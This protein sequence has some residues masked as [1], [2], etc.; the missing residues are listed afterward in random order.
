VAHR[1]A[2]FRTPARAAHQHE[3][4]WRVISNKYVLILALVYAGASRRL[5]VAGVWVPQLVKSFGLT[6]WQTAW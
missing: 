5:D 2:R 3:S 6:N 4:V 1:Q